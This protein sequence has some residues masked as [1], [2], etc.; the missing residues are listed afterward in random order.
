MIAL[1]VPEAVVVK[2]RDRVTGA[3][4]AIEQHGCDTLIL[5]DGFQYV[6]LERDENILLIDAT[7]PF[8]NGHLIPRGFLREPLRAMARA[9]AV[10]LTHCDQAADLSPVLAQVKALAP[11]APIRR[12]RHAPVGFCRLHDGQ[13]LPCTAVAGKRV[14]A[15]CGIGHPESMFKTLEDLGAVVTEQVAVPDHGTIP[16]EALNVSQDGADIVV[17]TEKDAVRIQGSGL[18]PE[19]ASEI[20]VLAIEL[21][22]LE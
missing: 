20:W 3:R 7:N 12:T 2:N 5:D 14:R 16:I 6:R 8:G 10:I 1:K 17:T 4:V 21:K 18:P 9:T 15:V 19:S 11:H 22:D 13:P